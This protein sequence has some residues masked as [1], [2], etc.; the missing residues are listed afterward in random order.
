MAERTE[1]LAAIRKRL[2]AAGPKGATRIGRKPVQTQEQKTS[3]MWRRAWAKIN[4]DTPGDNASAQ[5]D[6]AK[7]PQAK[8][9]TDRIRAAFRR[10]MQSPE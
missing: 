8:R 10:G 4:A 3:A 5:V 2:L 9:I 1:T 7:T 6:T